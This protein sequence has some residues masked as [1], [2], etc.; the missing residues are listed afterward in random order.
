[1]KITLLFSLIII[2]IATFSGCKKTGNEDVNISNEITFSE[3][4][5]EISNY[6]DCDLSIMSTTMAYSQA[7]EITNN[8]KNY[9]GKVIKMKGNFSVQKAETRNY[10]FC[11]I[12]DVTACCSSGFEFSLSD[13]SLV[14]PDD[15]PKDNEE[16]TVI[17]TFSTYF[18]G[19]KEY[20][21]LKDARIIR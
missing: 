16:I 6:I 11:N 19:E 12:G 14:Y 21:E 15:Y 5:S 18:E 9:I 7:V 10:Y 2:L 4:T 1:M 20:I 17:G 8:Y 3:K 13:T